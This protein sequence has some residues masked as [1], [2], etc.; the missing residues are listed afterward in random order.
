LDEFDVF[1]DPQVRKLTMQ[2]LIHV[3]KKMDHRQFIFITPQDISGLTP[4]DKLRIFKLNPPDRY[5][6]LQAQ[7]T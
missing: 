2:A 3:A 5:A 1:L 6:K 4:D 7:E